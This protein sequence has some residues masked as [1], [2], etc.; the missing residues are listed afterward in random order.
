MLKLILIATFFINV[1]GEVKKVKTDQVGYQTTIGETFKLEDCQTKANE[2]I[3]R[4]GKLIIA[5]LAYNGIEAKI[6]NRTVTVL[7]CRF[8]GN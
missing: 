2:Q 7:N 4:A 5:E 8:I 1:N 6:E 3:D